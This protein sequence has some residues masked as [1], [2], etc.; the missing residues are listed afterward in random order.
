MT[1]DTDLVDKIQEVR[2][3][4]NRLWMNLLRLALAA[5]P[6]NA[7]AILRQIR[8]N[9]LRISELMEELGKE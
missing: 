4:N 5:D 1:N 2:T 3:A 7:K 6:I 8:V 9:D